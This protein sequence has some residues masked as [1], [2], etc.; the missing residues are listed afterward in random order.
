MISISNSKKFFYFWSSLMIQQLYICCYN[1]MRIYE[2]YFVLLIVFECK[3]YIPSK[4]V[5]PQPC[6][7]NNHWTS[8]IC[9]SIIICDWLYKNSFYLLHNVLT[10]NQISHHSPMVQPMQRHVMA[11]EDLIDGYAQVNFTC[12]Y[13]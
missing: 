5:C 6:S 9:E 7:S 13:F 4:H 2:N 3:N 1:K 8:R 10:N 11:E 12:H